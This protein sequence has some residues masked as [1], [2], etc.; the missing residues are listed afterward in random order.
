MT[1]VWEETAIAHLIAPFDSTNYETLEKYYG[2]IDYKSGFILLNSINEVLTVEQYGGNIGFPKGSREATDHSAYETALREL[3]EETKVNA[4]MID[5]FPNI[6]HF[7]RKNCNELM[8]YFVAKL[9]F[10]VPI[11]IDNVEIVNYSW[12]K[13]QLLRNIKKKS[14]PT[15]RISNLLN[16]AKV[17]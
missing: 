11:V 14:T 7:H 12:K 3:Y 5:V 16:C 15:Y 4:D 10:D 8:L 2:A 6:F 17:I 13:M 1:R 9:K